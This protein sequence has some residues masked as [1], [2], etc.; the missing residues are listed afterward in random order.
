MTKITIVQ[1]DIT[2]S[3]DIDGIEV[4]VNVTDTDFSGK[5]GN[6]DKAIHK[7]VGEAL[8]IEC[9]KFSGCEA[10]EIKITNAFNLNCKKIFHIVDPKSKDTKKEKKTY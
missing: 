8:A 2:K 3:I 7:A 6:V 1:G 10:G 9:K 5:A 4:V